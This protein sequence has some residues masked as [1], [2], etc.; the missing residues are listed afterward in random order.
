MALLQ[1]THAS[2]HA[3]EVTVDIEWERKDAPP[4]L[5]RPLVSTCQR[6]EERLEVG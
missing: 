3:D 6:A 4:G 1:L 5:S 2:K